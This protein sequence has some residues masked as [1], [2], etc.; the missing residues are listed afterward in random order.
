[1]LVPFSQGTGTNQGPHAILATRNAEGLYHP[2]VAEVPVNHASAIR[3][4]HHVSRAV[5]DYENVMVLGGDHSLT[6]GV[7][8]AR[9][10]REGPVH[11]A[12]FD[13]HHDRYDITHSPSLMDHG[14]WLRFADG[15]G[16][17]SGITWFNYRGAQT[18]WGHD[19]IPDSGPVHVS[20]DLDVLAPVEIGW[21]TPCPVLGGG[22]MVEELL[23]AIRALPLT[24]S[25]T[26]TSDLVEYDPT[27][28][29]NRG[30]ARVCSLIMDA[31]LAHHG[32][33]ASPEGV[34]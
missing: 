5:G 17:L 3:T 21:A 15:A 13:A 34:T 12:L 1:L 25:H 30:A 18:T 27:G 26:V 33:F 22:A 14:N 24:D 28:D 7:L 32:D 16:L 19:A 31:L 11:L 8:E 9:A 20:V 2:R 23:G 10:Q 4:A 29:T 6:Y